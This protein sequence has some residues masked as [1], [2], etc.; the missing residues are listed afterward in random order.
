MLTKRLL[1]SY[2]DHFLFVRGYGRICS[3]FFFHFLALILVDGLCGSNRMVV[4]LS[5]RF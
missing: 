2:C 4:G 1:Q 3:D 5:G